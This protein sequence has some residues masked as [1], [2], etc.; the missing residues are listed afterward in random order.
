MLSAPQDGVPVALGPVV[1]HGRDLDWSNG[2]R[3]REAEQL[4]VVPFREG[5]DQALIGRLA[6]FE[7]H[8]NRLA[9]EADGAGD[10]HRLTIRA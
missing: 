10:K 8:R 1:R 6:P 7:Q 2:V 5:E 9:V 4:V 3:D